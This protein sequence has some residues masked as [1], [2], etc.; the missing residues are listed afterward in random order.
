MSSLSRRSV[1]AGRALAALTF[2]VAVGTRA[3]DLDSPKVKKL[4]RTVVRFKDD[5]LQVVVGYK[6]AQ[7]HLDSKWILLETC[8]SASSNQPVEIFREDVSLILPDGTQVPMPSQKK[9]AQGLPDLRRMLNQAR[10]TRDPL[11]G[12]FPGRTREERLGFFAVPGEQIVFDR[13]TVNRDTLAWG[14]LFF[15]SPKGRFEPGIYTLVMENKLAHVRLP[16]A[17]GIEGDLERVK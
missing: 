10:V 15:E 16:L 14:D 1:S 13:V 9:M 6:H 8:L 11:G 12:Y 7:L 2:V 3:A 17:L 4:G 5:M